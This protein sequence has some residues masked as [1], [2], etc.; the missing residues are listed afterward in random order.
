MGKKG[1][2]SLVFGFLGNI[3]ASL[4]QLISF[5]GGF[6]KKVN[7]ACAPLESGKGEKENG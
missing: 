3:M 6:F 2:S 4:D 5:I 7:T 1:V